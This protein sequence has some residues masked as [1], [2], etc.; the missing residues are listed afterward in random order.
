MKTFTVLF[1]TLFAIFSVAYSLN[2]KKQDND[3]DGMKSLMN[4][5]M[6]G[7]VAQVQEE[8]EQK[9]SAELQSALKDLLAQV[10]DEEDADGDGARRQ[11]DDGDR[12][13]ALLQ[14]E[15]GEEG[16]NDGARK[17]DD[18]DENDGDDLLAL[19][20][21]EEDD[22]GDG[23]EVQD[24][25]EEGGD[26]ITQGWFGK[27]FRGIRRFGGRVNRVCNKVG[28]YTQ[29]LKCLPR[30]QAEV[31]KAEEGDD[32]LAKDLIRRIVKVQQEGGDDA[33]AQ[34]FGKILRKARGFFKRGRGFIRGIRNRVGRIY[35]GYKGIKNCVRQY[36]G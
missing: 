32:E 22:G 13:L 31:Q 14:E 29:A 21:E 5:L 1:F 34:F 19:L 4:E 6:K 35:R 18:A 24:D 33:E 27:L 15:E 3:D 16:D 36:R 8:D 10:E 23:A 28:R 12:L 2:A 30:M 26:A 17:Q 9:S 20:Q 25:G 7:V 11:G